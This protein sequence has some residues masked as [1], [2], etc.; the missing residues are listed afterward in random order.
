MAD[1]AEE[2]EEFQERLDATFKAMDKQKTGLFACP[3]P[4]GDHISS[5]H[6]TQHF[7][8]AVLG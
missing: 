6:D 7:T 5:F 2:E 4:H 8:P 1:A 3:H